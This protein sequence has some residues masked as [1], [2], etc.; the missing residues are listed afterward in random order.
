MKNEEKKGN[1]SQKVVHEKWTKENRKEINSPYV[2][3]MGVNKTKQNSIKL[4]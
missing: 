3:K 4:I 2:L 1:E